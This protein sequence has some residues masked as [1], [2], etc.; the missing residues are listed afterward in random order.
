MIFD[1]FFEDP[2]R[3]KALINAEDMFDAKY[4][5]GVTYPNIA[6][7][8]ESVALEIHSGMQAVVG[9]GYKPVLSFARYSFQN[10]KPP[11]WAHSDRNIAQFLGLI[12]LSENEG[13][14]ESGGTVLLRHKE[15]KFESHP[16]VDFHK[17][18]LIHHANVKEAWTEEFYCPARFNRLLILNASL[19]H[20]AVGA[21]GSGREDGRLV[22]SVFFNLG[23]P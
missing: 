3:T 19:I 21:Y 9:P 11:H 10:T 18:I 15:Y 16:D 12:Y 8:P 7:I 5:D 23:T 22:V 6:K 20:A 2:R 13:I 17:Q 1:D 14:G 4:T